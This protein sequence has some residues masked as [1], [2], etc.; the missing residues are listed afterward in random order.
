MLSVTRAAVRPAARRVAS[1]TVQRRQMGGHAPAPE[2]TG[3]DKVVRGYFPEDYQRKFR[4]PPLP[5]WAMQEK[6]LGLRR[7]WYCFYGGPS[8]GRS[9]KV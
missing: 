9:V 4:L 7:T 8:V 1:A 3:I 2:W 5:V 6:A